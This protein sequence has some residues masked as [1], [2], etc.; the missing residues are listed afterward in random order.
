MVLIVQQVDVADCAGG[1][2]GGRK[3]ALD[4]GGVG[5]GFGSDVALQIR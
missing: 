2:G 5:L 3:S 1:E 4:E